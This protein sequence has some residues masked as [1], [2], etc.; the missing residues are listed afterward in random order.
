MVSIDL[1][2]Y[3]E[4]ILNHADICFFE[5]KDALHFLNTL[6]TLSG[7]KEI[8]E[9]P[10]EKHLEPLFCSH[11]QSVRKG[12]SKCG[13]FLDDF[14]K[15]IIIERNKDQ[16]IYKGNYEFNLFPK[17]NHTNHKVV[18]EYKKHIVLNHQLLKSIF[19]G[20]FL[21]R[22]ALKQTFYP[23]F[24]SGAEITKRILEIIKNK[25]EYPLQPEFYI[26]K[27]QKNKIDNDIQ[28]EYLKTKEQKFVLD[29]INR[30]SSSLHFYN[31]LLDDHLNSYFAN[32][33]V[34]RQLKDKGFIDTN[35]FILYDSVY[36]STIGS[37]PKR[38]GSPSE[39]DKEKQLIYAVKHRNLVVNIFNLGI[40]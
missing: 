11:I 32:G 21:C 16:V 12:R 2:G 19:L 35:G 5:K 23:A 20:G 10:T 9:N 26:V 7:G 18:D 40:Y 30:N 4:E 29:C 39:N 24:L 8:G 25:L 13:V 38:K 31:P 1:L 37:S 28:R 36:R 33:M 22:L 34:R 6:N 15:L 3:I 14:N 17:I 27:L